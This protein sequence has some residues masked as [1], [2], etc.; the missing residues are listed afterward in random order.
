MTEKMVSV[1]KEDVSE[2]DIGVDAVRVDTVDVDNY[3]GLNA[4]IVLV[5]LVWQSPVRNHCFSA[6]FKP[7]LSV[8]LASYN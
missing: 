2:S 6:D 3:H 5:Y 4:R 8:S 1:T 7:S